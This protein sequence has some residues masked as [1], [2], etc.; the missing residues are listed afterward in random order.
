MLN[1]FLFTS[2]VTIS[3]CIIICEWNRLKWRINALCAM[4]VAVAGCSVLVFVFTWWQLGCSRS[5]KPKKRD[6]Q[7]GMSY[8]STTTGLVNTP[9]SRLEALLL[10]LKHWSEAHLSVVE[11]RAWRLWHEKPTDTKG[12]VFLFSCHFGHKWGH[13]CSE[14]R[15]T[16]GHGVL[17]TDWCSFLL[18]K[19]Q[20]I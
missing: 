1:G 17:K 8:S 6:T 14:S 5:A 19:F 10:L 20:C 12:H 2:R 9:T 16:A 11:H 3:S 4:I 15:G 13:I 18:R 7:C